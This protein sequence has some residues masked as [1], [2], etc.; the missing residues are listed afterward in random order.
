MVLRRPLALQFVDAILQGLDPV[1]QQVA[2]D[3]QQCH[4]AGSEPAERYGGDQDKGPSHGLLLHVA[5]RWHDATDAYQRR[6][7]PQEFVLREL[8][9][10]RLIPPVG[11]P[12]V[13]T[14][15]PMCP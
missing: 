14:W 15:P 13:R 2:A 10:V 6:V 11:A 12:D 5:D 8:R 9:P 7:D 1:S 4:P 3:E